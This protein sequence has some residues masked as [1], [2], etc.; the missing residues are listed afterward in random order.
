MITTKQTTFSILLFS[1]VLFVSNSFAEDNKNINF[2]TTNIV[3]E[4][5]PEK[6]DIVKTDSLNNNFEIHIITREG[7][8][9]QTVPCYFWTV[10]NSQPEV[11][12]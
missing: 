1:L 6:N 9:K 7:L 2:K 11:T 3:F 10:N 4:R 12:K 5:V 8:E